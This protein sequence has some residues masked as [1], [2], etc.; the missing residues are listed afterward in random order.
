MPTW[1]RALAEAVTDPAELLSLLGLPSEPG[2][3][4]GHGLFPTRVPRGFIDRMRWGDRRDPLLLQV[5]PLALEREKI[6]GFVP[7]PL[8]ELAHMPV[9]GLLAKYHGR[10]LITTTGAC[11]IHCRYCFR[12][13]FPYPEANP[14]R[15][16]WVAVLDH[17]QADTGIEEII[18]SGG[19]PL[20]LS[21]HRLAELVAA[22]EEIPHLKRLRLH[23]RLPVVVPER[24]DSLL[25]GWLENTRLQK[26]LVVHCNHGR[27]IDARVRGALQRL[28]ATG[29]TLLN[30]S[31][32]LR[33]INDSTDTLAELSTALFTA[34]VLPYYLHQ[35]DPVAGAAHFA[36]PDPEAKAL[37]ANLAGSLPGYLVPRLVRELPG[38]DAKT[39]L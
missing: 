20:S 1:R 9:P 34:G 24:V 39:L 27:E 31:V 17:L 13:H 7:D 4:L 8:D 21:D 14:G 25:T 28:A 6:P 36:V 16:R 5:L 10:A 22:L 37:I 19:D 38:R 35:L 32:L 3:R 33:G 12:R 30:Q 29:T 11:A 23:T 18:L 15:D 2:A 26:V